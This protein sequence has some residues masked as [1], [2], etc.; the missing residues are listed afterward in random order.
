ML[1]VGHS[2]KHKTFYHEL[3]DFEKKKDILN[4]LKIPWFNT[5]C[6]DQIELLLKG[7]NALWLQFNTKL[8][9]GEIKHLK[10]DRYKK[11]ILWT[12][13]KKAIETFKE[14]NQ[15][16]YS[17]KPTRDIADVLRFVD[18]KTEFLSVLTPLQPRYSKQNVDKD[19][20]IAV[21]IAQATNIGNHRMSETS[22]ISYH[23]LESTYNQYMRLA[24]LRK[25]HDIIA[26]AISHLPIFPHY[27]FDL[28]DLLY[29]GGDGQKFEM[30]TP[31]SKA[32]HSRKYYNK[33]RGVSAYTLLSNHVPIQCEL[34]GA[35]EHESYFIFDS[36]YN[37]TSLIKPAIL[38]SDMH[39]INK[40]NFAI[41]HWFGAELRP[42][43]T[44]LKGELKNVFCGKTLTATEQ[45]LVQPAGQ[46]NEQ[47]IIEEKD[48]ISQI[49]TSLALKESNQSTLIKKLCSLPPQNRTRK[50]VYEFDKLI[51][52]IYTLKCIL[53]PEILKNVR[54]SQNRV[55]S[56]HN[57]RASISK[58]GGTK[59]LLGQTDLAAEISNQCNRIL[60]TVAIYY[61]SKILSLMLEKPVPQK[62][63]KQFI[64]KIKKSSPVAWQHL[65]FT[66]HFVFCDNKK[67]I[68]IENIIENL[69]LDL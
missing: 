31:T 61:N 45:F 12:K 50:A 57:L 16:L 51:R 62:Y 66:G 13:P 23:T 69:D 32:R 53:Y 19:Q 39:G 38:T 1:H 18:E 42:R 64:K 29:G 63:K 14:D 20:I 10:Y 26:N 9:R 4:S 68:S 36:W 67:I 11:K 54:R 65:H 3:N 46:I 55:E 59:A 22:D 40:E 52:S 21:L 34:I 30:K 2:I 37:N 43:F 33:G 7:F 8:D 5:D 41:L 47:I 58:I 6:K 56:Y 24:T 27:T 15:T 35:H 44:N 48:N 28:E 25:A 60:T 17:K 49:I